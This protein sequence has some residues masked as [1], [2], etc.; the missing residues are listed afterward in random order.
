MFQGQFAGFMDFIA[1]QYSEGTYYSLNITKSAPFICAYCNAAGYIKDSQHFSVVISGGFPFVDDQELSLQTWVFTGNVSMYATVQSNEAYNGV[2]EL[3]DG[4]PNAYGVMGYAAGVVLQ[5]GGYEDISL[6]EPTNNV[7]VFNMESFKWSIA[8]STGATLP[9]TYGG[10]MFNIHDWQGNDVLAFFTQLGGSAQIDGCM[11][12]CIY[13]IDPSTSPITVTRFTTTTPGPEDW[14]LIGVSDPVNLGDS[15]S[16]S[17]FG[18]QSGS[19][20]GLYSNQVWFLTFTPG[21]S[22]TWTQVPISNPE[23]VMPRVIPRIFQSSEILMLGSGCN[24]QQIMYDLYYLNVTD[25]PLIDFQTISNGYVQSTASSI[26]GNIYLPGGSLYETPSVIPY[27][28]AVYFLANVTDPYGFTPTLPISLTA[29]A[30]CDNGSPLTAMIVN[31]TGSTFS[32]TAVYFVGLYGDCSATFN[33]YNEV[34]NYF[35]RREIQFLTVMF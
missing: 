6:S 5:Y 24:N 17:A 12:N 1:Y 33:A 32:S 30:Q 20:S 18:G 14:T 19:I 7:R 29:T 13:I 34:C 28:A 21:G 23:M 26:V 15:Y 27:G 25:T 10:S 9:S 3:Y 4:Q 8:T 16:V 31:A 22:F 11:F 2:W 35:A